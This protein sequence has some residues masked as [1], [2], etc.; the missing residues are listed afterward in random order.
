[1]NEREL[2]QKEKRERREK[3]LS[4]EREDGDTWDG[5]VVDGVIGDARRLLSWIWYNV[6]GTGE[7]DAEAVLEGKYRQKMFFGTQN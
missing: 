7:Q 3:I 5:I 6:G 4:G 2:S 1:M